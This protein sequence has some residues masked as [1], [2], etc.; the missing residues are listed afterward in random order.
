M[1]KNIEIYFKDTNFLTYLI[2]LK[3]K[4]FRDETVY[5]NF[6]NGY[7]ISLDLERDIGIYNPE[8]TDIYDDGK[9]VYGSDFDIEI[10]KNVNES[11]QEIKKWFKNYD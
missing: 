10:D 5:I 3:N 7:T 1:P 9:R 8:N 11:L 2:S 4:L 6:K